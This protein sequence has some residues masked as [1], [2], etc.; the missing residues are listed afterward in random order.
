MAESGSQSPQ[1]RL[2]RHPERGSH[3]R[4]QAYAVLDAGHIAHVGF[5][6][7]QQP[8]VIPMLYARLDDTLLL[9]GSIASRVMQQ[10]AGGAACC[11][12]VTH[13]D[14][15]VLARSHFHHSAN[16][17]SVV[18]LGQARRIDDP[19][20]KET[21][22]AHLVDSLIPGRAADTRPG[23]A[24]E[25]AATSLI[26]IDIVDFSV[27]SRSGPP[28]DHPDDLNLYAWAGEIP[29]SLRAGTPVP[30][31]DLAAGIELPSYLKSPEYD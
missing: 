16:Y 13:F 21:A 14:G 8:F 28:K 30:A 5:A 4:A 15:W 19:V 10:L 31:P 24:Q 20:R 11:V 25:L 23:D 6:L 7:D 27:K 18:I 22:L 12:T 2:R 29:L 9:H 3:E 1:L 17:R 26:A